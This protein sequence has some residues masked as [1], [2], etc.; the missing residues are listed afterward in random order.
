MTLVVWFLYIAGGAAW[1]M[2]AQGWD[3]IKGI[4]FAVGSLSTGGLDSPALTPAGTIPDP[5]AIF[6]G[7][8]C[9][10]GIP[11]FAMALGKFANTLI[12]RE[13]AE[14]E[15]RA[16]NRYITAD[17]FNCG[18]TL[19]VDGRVDLAEFLALELLRMR[20][21]SMRGRSRS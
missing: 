2:L 21:R 14:R 20:A 4:H 3:L 15:Q 9:F 6:I 19:H 7:V 8:Y 18:A 1:A 12:E 16:L 10:T 11:I 5:S 13:L 17:E